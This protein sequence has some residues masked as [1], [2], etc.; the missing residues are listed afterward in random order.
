MQQYGPYYIGRITPRSLRNWLIDNPL[1]EGDTV[2]MHPHTYEDFALGYREEY[3]VSM[4]EPYFLLG[5]LIDE[6]PVRS[7]YDVPKQRVLVL[8]E[9]DR[10]QRQA[11]MQQPAGPV[12]DGRAVYRCGWC[13]NLVDASGTGLQGQ[14]RSYAKTLLEMRGHRA[15]RHVDGRCCPNGHS[16]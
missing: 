15:T 11:F 6:T 3:S 16:R 4:P 10:P 7:A 1:G 14:E 2:L 12:D 13:G 8:V 9:D 5:V